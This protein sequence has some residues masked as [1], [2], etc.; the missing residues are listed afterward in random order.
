[1]MVRQDEAVA[2]PDHTSADTPAATSY[3]YDAPL[4]VLYHPDGGGV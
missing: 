2:W 1:M 3:L 4:Y